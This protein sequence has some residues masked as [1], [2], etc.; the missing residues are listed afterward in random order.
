MVEGLP[1]PDS[2]DLELLR[3][4]A[5]RNYSRILIKTVLAIFGAILGVLATVYFVMEGNRDPAATE[6]VQHLL[7]TSSL[8]S[9]AELGEEVVSYRQW[10]A[11]HGTRTEAVLFDDVSSLLI[12]SILAS[13]SQESSGTETGLLSRLYTSLHTGLIRLAFLVIASLRAWF[14][15]IVGALMLGLRHYRAYAGDDALGQMGN[16]RL[17]YSGVRAGLERITSHGAPDVQVRGFACPQF[18]TS[19]EA[20]ASAIWKVLGHYGAQNE[21]NE[22]L[23]AILVKNGSISPYVAP[24]EEDALLAKAFTGSTLAQNTPEILSAALSLHARYAAGEVSARVQHIA[25]EPV[26]R[27]FS[28]EEYA[29]ALG[30]AMNRVLSPVM[31][32]EL[33]SLP[34]AEVATAILALECGKVLAHS[35][36]GG[37]WIKR[38]QFPQLSARAVL[39]SVLA[40]PRDYDFGSRLR[41]R[42]ALIYASRSSSFAPVRMPLGLE[43]DTWVVRQWMEVLLSNPHDLPGVADEVEL[44]G[45]VRAAHEAWCRE[46]LD[47]SSALSPEIAGASY[48][49]ASGLLFVPLSKVIELLK[50]SVSEAEI[51]RMGELLEL[52]S[53]RQRLKAVEVAKREGEVSDHVSFDRI[54]PPLRNAEVA[55]LIKLHNLSESEVR[56]WSALRIVLTSYGWLARRVGDYTVPESSIIFAVFKSREPLAGANSLGLVGTSGMVP[57]RGAKLEARWG[58]SWSSRF[59][60]ADKATMAE[61]TEDYEKLM[62]GIEE[63]LEE[64]AAGAIP[65]VSA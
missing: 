31:R 33:G 29:E 27:P 62:K 18:S 56:D 1:T 64:E 2:K 51:H 47:A 41:I 34:A 23:V 57:F 58:S 11:T 24:P 48:S 42:R 40:Y 21:T 17:F 30:S 26:D 52:V 35:F 4:T 37:R 14:V 10:L 53:N 61:S 65:P 45:L 54:F 22:T 7:A 39:H 60:Y 32:E 46:F 55:E 44:V 19:A 59:T 15:V 38:S 13:Q 43:P 3:S 16:G 50:R 8:E 6:E 25:E 28:S 20:R 5:R 36:E 9:K 63:K 12:R 49:T